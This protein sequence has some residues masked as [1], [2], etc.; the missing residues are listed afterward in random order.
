MIPQPGQIGSGAQSKPKPAASRATATGARSRSGRPS[1]E[2]AYTGSEAT[3][4]ARSA[5]RVT[6]CS[7]S[8]WPG[9]DAGVGGQDDVDVGLG[10]VD[11]RREA[12]RL[13]RGERLG[14]R[15]AGGNGT[16]WK[17]VPSG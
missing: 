15:G 2:N 10:H 8:R 9:C 14:G 16:A 13:E 7:D 3:V 11:A 4:A 6:P 5:V 17:P 12:R 1:T